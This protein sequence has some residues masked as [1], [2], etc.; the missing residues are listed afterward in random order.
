MDN[1]NKNSI[2]Y[3]IV[4]PHNKRYCSFYINDNLKDKHSMKYKD[5]YLFIARK[6]K[7]PIITKVKE[8]IYSYE[9][10]VVDVQ[11]NSVQQITP[12]STEYLGI[13][14]ISFKEIEKELRSSKKSDDILVNQEIKINDL[15]SNIVDKKRKNKKEKESFIYL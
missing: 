3:I 11:N 7:P 14:K 2:D 4:I 15:Y 10:F 13:K 6:V 5:M 12:V 9:N 1:I 8:L